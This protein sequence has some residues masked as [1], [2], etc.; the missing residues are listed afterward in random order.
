[1]SQDKI[2]VSKVV[3]VI[4]GKEIEL[5]PK[6]AMELKKVLNDTFPEK[7]TVYTYP[8]YYYPVPYSR[9][10]IWGDWTAEYRGQATGGNTLYLS[11]GTGNAE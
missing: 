1:M 9:P 3:L 4:S 8:I 10:Y 7:E 2:E 11:A 5:T 6:E